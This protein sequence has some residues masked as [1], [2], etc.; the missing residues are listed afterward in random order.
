[1]EIR[2]GTYRAPNG[3]QTR[4]S[5][6]HKTRFGSLANAVKQ[7]TSEVIGLD[8]NYDVVPSHARRHAE[9]PGSARLC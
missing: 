7:G 8:R 2:A 6:S 5:R 9:G 1:M 3:P 4:P